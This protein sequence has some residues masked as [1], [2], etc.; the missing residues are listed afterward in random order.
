MYSKEDLDKMLERW[1]NS[2]GETI[3]KFFGNTDVQRITLY[4][5]FPG[6]NITLTSPFEGHKAWPNIVVQGLEFHLD[7]LYP[8]LEKLIRRE[9]AEGV[10]GWNGIIRS[11]YDR[12]D[13]THTTDC[14][15]P[16][17][18]IELM[19]YRFKCD[20]MVRAQLKLSE[21]SIL[22]VV[23]EDKVLFREPIGLPEGIKNGDIELPLVIIN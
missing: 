22:E 20:A 14:H 23:R 4:G 11:G 3:R 8:H 18:M 16:V 5:I 19:E 12:I 2:R 7:L 15:D 21:V 9:P 17:S 6:S 10:A 13:M 1:R